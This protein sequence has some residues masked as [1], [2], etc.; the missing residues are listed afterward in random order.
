MD[1]KVKITGDS[2]Y[3][4]YKE[5]DNGFV[6]GYVRGADDIPYAV[7]IVN[8]RFSLVPLSCLRIRE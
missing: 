3:N 6:N 8:S 5:G 7:V 2:P 4:E 1:I